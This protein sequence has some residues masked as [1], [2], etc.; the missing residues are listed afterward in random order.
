MTS[1]CH[2]ISSSVACSVVRNEDTKK[3]VELAKK[4]GASVEAEIAIK[5]FKITYDMSNITVSEDI[6]T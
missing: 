5:I 3:A 6:D 2:L 1:N 4:F